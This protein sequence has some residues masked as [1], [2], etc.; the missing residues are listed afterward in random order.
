MTQSNP[1]THGLDK[2]P[3]NYVP[4]SPL[5]F[6]ERSAYVH[7][8]H[9]AVV[10]GARRF[11]WAQSF[12]R[13]KQLASA[14]Q[15]LGVGE[16]HTVS[17]MAHNCHQMFEAHFGIPALGAVIH[18]INTRLDAANI[19]F[20]LDHAESK[21]LIADKEFSPVIQEALAQMKGPKPFVVDM[22]SP[23][24]TSGTR[25]GK[26]TYEEL[27]ATGTSDFPWQMPRDE[28]QAIALGYTSGTTGNPKGVVT[29][30]RGAYL[31]AISN[32]LAWDM[33]RHSVYLWTLPMFHCNGWCYPWTLAAISGTNVCL[34][35]VETEK[36]YE[37]IEKEGVTHYCGAPIV[38]NWMASASPELQAKKQNKVQGMVAAAPPPLPY[39]PPWK[40]MISRSPMY[41]A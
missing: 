35:K 18:A 25:I 5:T 10:D 37:L 14:L 3:A 36:I 26:L 11:T 22:D 41:M 30:H 6:I 31:N 39:L 27:L 16:G 20:M 19:A 9:L 28:W 34:R 13:C 24:A 7:P 1:Y 33:P 29:H 38:H 17:I 12:A 40:K 2:N 32:L 23:Q 4:L 21:V 15:K 8:D